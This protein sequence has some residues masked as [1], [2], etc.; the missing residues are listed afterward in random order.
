MYF[1]LG[2]DINFD[3]AFDFN[4]NFDLG[5]DFNFTFDLDLDLNPDFKFDLPSAFEW[6]LKMFPVCEESS[7]FHGINVEIHWESSSI[8]FLNFD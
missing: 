1:A 8:S 2:L 6:C 7:V 4:F 3:F 5:L